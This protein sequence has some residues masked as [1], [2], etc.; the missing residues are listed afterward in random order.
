MYIEADFTLQ[1]KLT[2]VRM[3]M[4][5]KFRYGL[6]PMLIRAAAFIGKRL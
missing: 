6:N 2:A 4:I 5:Q 3:K 1:R